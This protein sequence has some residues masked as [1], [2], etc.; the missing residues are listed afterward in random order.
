MKIDLG[1]EIVFDV[2]LNGTVHKL[3]E[4]SVNDVKK[5]RD[6]EKE[7]HDDIDAFIDFVV[8]LGMPQD[9]AQ[10]LGVKKLQILSEGLIGEMKKKD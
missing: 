3:R 2:H 6:S 5:L 10:N 1:D 9:V 8:R 4:P 7:G